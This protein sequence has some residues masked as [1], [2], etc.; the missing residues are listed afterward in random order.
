MRIALIV[1]VLGLFAGCVGSDTPNPGLTEGF[2]ST[3]YVGG[4]PEEPPNSG[5]DRGEAP[6]PPS[7]TTEHEDPGYFLLGS[8]RNEG[9]ETLNF[10]VASHDGSEWTN[11]RKDRA[12]AM[13]ESG[14][15]F[16]MEVPCS[17][18]FSR[19]LVALFTVDDEL[20]NKREF[21]DLACKGDQGAVYDL[22]ITAAGRI[23]LEGFN[24]DG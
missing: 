3:G 7:P 8:W 19:I 13:E 21:R 1:A 12:D 14:W 16:S 17:A 6:P 9:F 23:L 18:Q 5:S 4:E 22:T 15:G 2:T 20:V 10:L 24:A 11:G